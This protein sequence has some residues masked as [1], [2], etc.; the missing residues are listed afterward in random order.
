[1]VFPEDLG[2]FTLVWKNTS[3]TSE[4]C[5]KEEFYCKKGKRDYLLY[6]EGGVLCQQKKD[7]VVY[8]RLVLYHLKIESRE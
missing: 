5:E 4:C 1:M 6:W 2:S 8:F 7:S 3:K